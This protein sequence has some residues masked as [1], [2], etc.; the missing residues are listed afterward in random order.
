LASN[1]LRA[2]HQQTSLLLDASV[3]RCPSGGVCEVLWC[4]SEI[5]LL[6]GVKALWKDY[7]S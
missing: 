7:L 1:K 4:S 6:I 3:C 5:S 2:S